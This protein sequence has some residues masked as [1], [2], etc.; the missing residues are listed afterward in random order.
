MSSDTGELSSSG[1]GLQDAG[2]N[3]YLPH[4]LASRCVAKLVLRL[5]P[6]KCCVWSLPEYGSIQYVLDVRPAKCGGPGVNVCIPGSHSK[7]AALSKGLLEL[8]RLW[9]IML[10]L[11]AVKI[12]DSTVSSPPGHADLLFDATSGVDELTLAPHLVCQFAKVDSPNCAPSTCCVAFSI[13]LPKL[14]QYLDSPPQPPGPPNFTPNKVHTFTE[15]VNE[16]AAPA[17]VLV[18]NSFKH[19]IQGCAQQGH[20][21]VRLLYR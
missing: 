12:M 16:A 3:Q 11:G 21:Q 18:A 20:S 10:G 9:T 6:G 14:G 17:C 13:S 19:P 15:Y 1:K 7:G 5:R 8:S 4:T 2:S